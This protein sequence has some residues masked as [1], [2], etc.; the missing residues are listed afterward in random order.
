MNTYT[1]GIYTAT[2]TDDNHV[3]VT[4]NG[5][6]FNRPGPWADQQGADT[7]AQVAPAYYTIEDEKA[8]AP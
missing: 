2:V 6:L 8:A 1:H 5:V 4:K 3:E 7:W